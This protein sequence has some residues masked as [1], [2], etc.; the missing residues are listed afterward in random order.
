MISQGTFTYLLNMINRELINT[1]YNTIFTQIAKDL[2]AK[3]VYPTAEQDG[4]RKHSKNKPVLPFETLPESKYKDYKNGITAKSDIIYR[5]LEIEEK[6]K[7]IMQKFIAVRPVSI[8][9]S[10]LGAIG[11]FAPDYDGSIR[12][13]QRAMNKGHIVNAGILYVLESGILK[14]ITSTGTVLVEKSISFDINPQN[15]GGS[16]ETMDEVAAIE[17]NPNPEDMRIFMVTK[18]GKLIIYTL[19]MEKQ[20]DET[21]LMSSTNDTSDNKLNTTEELTVEE[22]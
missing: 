2:R 1:P 4:K 15:I 21:Q 6:E 12:D 9:S 18:Q 19:S 22:R 17:T 11:R 5:L 3:Q 13:S 14:I 10:S 20:F 16:I 7:I 8:I